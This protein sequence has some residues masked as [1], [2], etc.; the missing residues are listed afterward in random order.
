MLQQN[1]DIKAL[2]S[3]VL[4]IKNSV[5]P[6]ILS[7]SEPIFLYAFD[8]IKNKSEKDEIIS[9]MHNFKCFILF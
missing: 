2:K 1:E 4:K 8:Q 3:Y 9:K 6:K 7:A 5:E